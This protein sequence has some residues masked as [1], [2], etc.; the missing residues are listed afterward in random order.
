MQ[1]TPIYH[2]R[3]EHLEHAVIKFKGE[4]WDGK[5]LDT[6]VT[7]NGMLLCYISWPEKENFLKDLKEVVDKYII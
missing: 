1:T 6:E 3:S 2:E 5:T 7:I 4:Q